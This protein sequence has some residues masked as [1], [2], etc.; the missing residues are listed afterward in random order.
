M[1]DV[2]KDL[3]EYH[4]HSKK[5]SG[6]Y[7]VKPVAHTSP[8]YEVIPLE[9]SYLSDP[10]QLNFYPSHSL[11]YKF[12]KFLLVLCTFPFSLIALLS[13]VY[14]IPDGC[15]GLSSDGGK[16]V[17]LPPGWHFLGSPFRSIEKIV[18][19]GD[20]SVTEF[21]PRGFC[22]V[23]DGYVTVSRQN[24]RYVILGP[25]FHS[26]DDPMFECGT[27]VKLS[28]HNMLVLGPYTVVTVPPGEIAITEDNGTLVM[29]SENSKTGKRCHFLDH[30]NWKFRGML[31]LQRQIDT[32]SVNVTTADRVEV[33]VQATAAW[34]IQDP[35][36]AAL[37]G[38]HD[39][40]RLQQLVHRSVQG[41]LAHIV[42]ARRISDGAVDA[43]MQKDESGASRERLNHCDK[44]FSDIGIE[45][46][47]IAIVQMHIVNETIR[48]E[49][50]KISAIPAK[51]KELRDVADAQAQSAVTSAKGQAAA[52]LEVAQAEANSIRM[53]A[54]ARKEAGEL[55]GESGSTASNLAYI[56]ATGQAL[57]NAKSSVFFVP[58]G[59]VRPLMANQNLFRQ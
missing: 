38:G 25:G 13:R 16:R 43:V 17:F 33:Q 54:E 56:E 23:S 20:P 5:A 15:V 34:T 58:P 24:G 47:E 3:R 12:V 50:A 29:L 55:L 7:Y 57:K 19:L 14:I 41:V 10:T 52:M 26:W 2:E 28:E 59:D 27:Y 46:T 30:A 11:W 49:I 31:S 42:S 32:V 39:M 44:E 6:D 21:Y 4:S 48:M 22:L 1:S 8:C 35:H 53:I 45:M 51:T 9:T 40:V 36:K 37:R 18:H